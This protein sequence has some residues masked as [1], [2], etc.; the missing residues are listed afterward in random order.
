MKLLIGLGNPGKNYEKTRHNIGFQVIDELARR[1][2]APPFQQK[3]NGQYTTIHTPEG[4]VILLK[5]MTYMNLSGECVR[6]LA[7]YFEVN[8][9]ELLV[10]YD[11]LDLPAGKIRLRQKGSAGG[12]NGM[13]SIIAHMATSEFN[14]I[15][16][17]VDRPSGGMKVSDYVLSPFG[18]DE[19]PLMEEAIQKSADAC[20]E[21]VHR[22]TPFLEVMNKFNGS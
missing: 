4:K 10:L 20:E 14:R 15:R 5:P 17:G 22:N 2:Q 21:W 13:K 3:F 18:K 12:H 9:E 1:W 19:Q 7:D 11:D 16:I 6:P 8:D